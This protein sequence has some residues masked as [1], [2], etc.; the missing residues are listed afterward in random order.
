MIVRFVFVTVVV[1][2]LLSAQGTPAGWKVI[3]DLE[4]AC[5]VAVPAAWDNRMVQNIATEPGNKL[6]AVVS[7]SESDK[8]APLSPAEL[9]VLGTVKVVE[10]SAKRYFIQSKEFKDIQGGPGATRTW[11]SAVPAKPGSCR[12]DVSLR[13][14][15]D[16]ATAEKVINSLASGAFKV[17]FRAT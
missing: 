1:S 13:Q 6:S 15:A 5:Q 3:K 12:L 14:G 11:R 7:Y 17:R 9:T 10:N 8:Y 2:G 4:E 16:E